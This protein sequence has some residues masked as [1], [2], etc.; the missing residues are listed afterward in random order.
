MHGILI[1]FGDI[2]EKISK[3]KVRKWNNFPE[4]TKVNVLSSPNQYFLAVLSPDEAADESSFAWSENRKWLIVVDGYI[5][6]K[7]IVAKKFQNNHL[8]TL[9]EAINRKGI[10]EALSLIASGSF[11]AA[12]I[13][14]ENNFFFVIN[15]RIGSI[16]LY[17]AQTSTGSLFS[18]NPIAL[19]SSGLLAHE[20]DYTACAEFAFFGYTIGSRCFSKSLKMFPPSSMLKWSNCEQEI[21][22]EQSALKFNYM[23]DTSSSG[24][25]VD[26]L[27]KSIRGASQR[28]SDQPDR[29]AH[30]QS[31]GMDSRLILASWPDE[32]PIPCY[33]YGNHNS[34]E[35]MVAKSIADTKGSSFHHFRP[36]GDQIA[37]NLDTMFNRSGMMVYPDRFAI[38]EQI[39]KD[40][41][42]AILDGFLGGALSGFYYTF[43]Q[44]LFPNN[45]LR[46]LLIFKD[47]KVSQLGLEKLTNVLYKELCIEDTTV[48]SDYFNND[49]AT[50]LELQK[51]D[52]MHDIYEELKIHAP[53]NDSVALL[54]RN[55]KIANRAIH[56]IAMQGVMTRQF[57]QVYLPFS[58]DLEYN[59]LMLNLDPK[60][61]AYKKLYISL[62]KKH[63]PAYAELL[64]GHSK[65]PLKRS[66]FSHKWA[67]RLNKKK[68]KIPYLT[69]NNFGL[70]QNPNNWNSWLKESPSLR[71]KAISYFN[72]DG[73]GN[74]ENVK[75]IFKGIEEGSKKGSGKIFHLA[76][77][78]NWLKL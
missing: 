12:I 16:P 8:K 18:T 56:A 78:A 74:E 50:R 40:G 37:E 9:V 43:D 29:F 52:M 76:G 22:I 69:G 21:F 48:V 54:F 14:T 10:S 64:Y 58:G 77:I 59:D 13:D 3:E 47:Q 61:V 44:H 62:F 57:V 15:D 51:D 26:K 75:R 33:T 25:M 73:I 11:N 45:Y 72:L 4:R 31:A 32:H 68:L 6:L 1:G 7:S 5:I 28:I 46:L 53:K 24:D 35:A 55:F 70:N 2:T 63:F 66:P 30:L 17:Y 39:R 23:P 71:D 27:A 19:V 49:I 65:L 67:S 41:Y 60:H 20:I 42:T 34:Y 36:S 38:A